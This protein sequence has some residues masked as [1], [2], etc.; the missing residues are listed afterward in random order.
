MIFDI[1][2]ILLFKENKFPVSFFVN[3]ID[4]KNIYI[5]MEAGIFNYSCVIYNRLINYM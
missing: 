1:Q 5:K 2:P 3:I 4:L